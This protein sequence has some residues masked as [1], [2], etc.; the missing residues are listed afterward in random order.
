[1]ADTIYGTLDIGWERFS[2]QIDEFSTLVNESDV[3]SDVLQSIHDN[4]GWESMERTFW[5]FQFGYLLGVHADHG[6]NSAPDVD[7]NRGYQ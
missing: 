1:M 2:K 7:E 4:E 3:V 6:P 5:A